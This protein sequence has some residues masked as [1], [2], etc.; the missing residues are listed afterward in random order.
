MPV[1]RNGLE[2]LDRPECLRLLGTGTV[3]RLAVCSGAGPVVLPVNYVLAGEDI[4]I[5]TAEGSGIHHALA[6]ERVAFEVDDVDPAYEWGWSVLV[7]GRGRYLD[8]PAE[9]AR[10]ERLPLRSWGPGERRRF[11]AIAT[12]DLSGR[13]IGHHG[14]PQR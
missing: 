6:T 5:G 14:L 10:A 1:D 3:G 9:V 12:T 7:T 11:T 8:E 4:V 13:R 2:V